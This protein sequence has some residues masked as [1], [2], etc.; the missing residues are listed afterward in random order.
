MVAAAPLAGFARWNAPP[1]EILDAALDSEWSEALLIGFADAALA[2]RDAAWSLALLERFAG[3]AGGVIGLLDADVL[4]GLLRLLAPQAREEFLL[5]ILQERPRAV[6][7]GW[8]QNLLAA[9]DHPW[10]EKASR[11]LL[12][13]VRAHYL[14]ESPWQLRATL[15]RLAAH[16]SPGVGGELAEDWPRDAQQWTE[17]DDTMLARLTATFELRRSYLE[18][19]SR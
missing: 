6:H 14:H 13:V 15:V 9:A 3:R 7:D 5:G 18:E 19:F 1:G 12:K 11:R 2:Q 16:L 17:G 10:S 8:V 4:N